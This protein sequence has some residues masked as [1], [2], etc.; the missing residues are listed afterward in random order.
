M[1]ILPVDNGRHFNHSENP[2]TSSEYSDVEEE[3]VT[4]AVKNISPGEEMTENYGAY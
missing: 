1:Q 3:V 4:R 2:N